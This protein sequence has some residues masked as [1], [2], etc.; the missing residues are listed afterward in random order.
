[1]AQGGSGS[2]QA[3]GA[4]DI[5]WKTNGHNRQVTSI[6]IAPDGASLASGS[7][8]DGLYG[9]LNV[10]R[11]L[12]TALVK[13][14]AFYHEDV[15][16]VAISPDGQYLA[17]GGGGGDSDGGKTRMWQISDWTLVTIHDTGNFI[18]AVAFS[19]DSD[20]YAFAPQFGNF[21]GLVPLKPGLRGGS[22]DDAPH[23]GPVNS[24]QFAPNAR[25][26]ASAG[27]TEWSRF[28]IT[29]TASLTTHS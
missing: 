8:E 18:T 11:T 13:S 4:P 17:E 19:A 24:I 21:I 26:F 25:T 10:W 16:T 7:I 29:L 12:D 22:T 15:L 9:Y 3:Q 20:F 14:F 2:V 1:M 28:G 23:Y 5:V 27:G 6:A